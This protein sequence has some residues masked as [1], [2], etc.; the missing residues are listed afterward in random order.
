[1]EH[2]I[3]DYPH[4][5]IAEEMFRDKVSHAKPKKDEVTINMVLVVEMRS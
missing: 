4:K 5:L 3:Y 1:M 2:K